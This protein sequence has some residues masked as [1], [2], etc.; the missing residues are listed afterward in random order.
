[1][2]EYE[3]QIVEFFKS[4]LIHFSDE[5]YN[6]W[7]ASADWLILDRDYQTPWESGELDR[8]KVLCRNKTREYK[9]LLDRLQI[10]DYCLISVLPNNKI[11]I[12]WDK[13]DIN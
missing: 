8:L 1:M 10:D 7:I 9:S 4:I 3:K 12:K 11:R 13:K 6:S 5:I 2:G